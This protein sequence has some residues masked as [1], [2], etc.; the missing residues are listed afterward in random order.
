M[1]IDILTLFP[2]MIA[3]VVGSSILGRAAQK[4]ILSFNIVNIRDH[5]ENKHRKT[6]DTSYGGGA[7]MVMMAQPVFDAL[8]SVG[9]E[10]KKIIYMS[11][12]GRIADEQMISELAGE[13][14]LVFLC[15]HYEGID[16]R[17]IDYWKPEEISIGDY[18]LT[19]GEL[20]ALVVIDAVSRLVPGV[21][22]NADSAMGESVYSGLLEHPQYTK[23]RIYEGMEVPEVLLSGDHEAIRLWQLKEACKVT[24][25]RRSDLWNKYISEAADSELNKAER[26]IMAE[27]SG[28][29]SFLKKKRKNR[30]DG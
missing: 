19:G 5:T 14:D 6:D 4:G 12:K 20:A 27:V 3:P 29:L 25:D 23:P 16:Q 15:G 30:K 10:N 8:R 22:G 28:D 2:E 17:V 13:R 9:A 26:E 18:I 7:G 21:L 24:R 11:P 1:N